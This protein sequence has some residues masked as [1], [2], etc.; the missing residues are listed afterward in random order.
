MIVMVTFFVLTL[1]LVL[2]RH[3][4]GAEPGCWVSHVAKKHGPDPARQP[5]DI[6][7]N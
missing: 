7:A 5:A 6:R 3:E 4:V 2:D 1:I